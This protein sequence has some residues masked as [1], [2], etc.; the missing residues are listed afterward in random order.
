MHTC[1]KYLSVN[2]DHTDKYMPKIYKVSVPNVVNTRVSV[3]C[4][5]GAANQHWLAHTPLTRDPARAALLSHKLVIHQSPEH[6]DDTNSIERPGCHRVLAK[7]VGRYGVVSPVLWTLQSY[8]GEIFIQEFIA[9]CRSVRLVCLL[10]ISRYWTTM[11]ILYTAKNDQKS[12]LCQIMWD[13][14]LSSK[15]SA[16]ERTQ[17]VVWIFSSTVCVAE[18]KKTPISV[19]PTCACWFLPHFHGLRAYI[20]GKIS[21]PERMNYDV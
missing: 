14:I 20:F 4:N 21:C 12:I 16:Y 18:Q 7:E 15:I 11:Y 6:C 2:S 3:P 10:S 5:I 8:R 19:V 17:K 13:R 9:S 1:S